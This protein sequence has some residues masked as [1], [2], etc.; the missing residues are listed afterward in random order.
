MC[1]MRLIAVICVLLCGKVGT[2]FALQISPLPPLR[3]QLSGCP[4]NIC[5]LHKLRTFVLG[6]SLLLNPLPAAP[7]ALSLVPESQE[8]LHEVPEEVEDFDDELND[9]AQKMLDAMYDAGGIGLAGA[10]VY[11]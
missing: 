11:N 9:L 2:V 10:Y 7:A 4:Q 6:A 1:V 3:P 5:V 8:I